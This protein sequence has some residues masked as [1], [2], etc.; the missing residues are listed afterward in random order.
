MKD[1]SVFPSAFGHPQVT[2]QMW[3]EGMTVIRNL[4]GR[5]PILRGMMVETAM[6]LEASKKRKTQ[7]KSNEKSKF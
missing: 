1:S 7:T 3:T 4:E 5:K 2:A 6:L